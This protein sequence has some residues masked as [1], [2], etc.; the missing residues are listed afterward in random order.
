MSLTDTS[1]LPSRSIHDSALARLAGWCYDHRKWVLLAWIVAIVAVNVV[2]NVAGSRLTNNLSGGNQPIQQILDRAFPGQ[3]GSQNT[4]VITTTGPVTAPAVQARTA[5]MVRA[6]TPLAHV[7]EVVPPFSPTGRHQ[8]SRDGH[9]AYVQVNFDEQT[10][11]LPTGAINKVISTAQ[12]FEAPGYKVDLGGPAIDLV[13]GGK[14]GASEGIGIL[15]AIII[16][17]IAFGSVVAMGLPIITALFGIVA[18]IGILDLV[19]HI[20]TTPTFAPEIMAMIGLGVGIDYALFVVTRYRQG[21][22]EGRDPRSGG[23]LARHLRPVGDLRRHHRDPLAARTVHPAARVHA[24]PRDQRHRGRTPRHARR[25]DPPPRDARIL[26][27]RNRPIPGAGP[28][29]HGGGAGTP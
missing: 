13:A 27:T 16:M 4:V 15:A 14:P 20:E 10:G 28:A 17:L 7:S 3:S 29:P 18:G 24:R 21:L 25:S 6:L 22:T 8:I 1:S 12:S 26:R 5:D 2:G 11:N 19:S 23:R 9:I